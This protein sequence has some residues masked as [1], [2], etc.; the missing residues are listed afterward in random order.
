LRDPVAQWGQVVKFQQLLQKGM[1]L[2]CR[3]CWPGMHSGNDGKGKYGN[4]KLHVPISYIYQYHQ[5][6]SIAYYIHCSYDDSLSKYRFH[7]NDCIAWFAKELK[8]LAYNIK[9][10]LSTNISMADFTRND[11]IKFNTDMYCHVCEKPF[12]KDDIRVR[13]HC[14]LTERYIEAPCIQIAT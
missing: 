4:I 7:D 14:H 3:I 9:T 10:I 1:R 2:I 13:D 12:A 5:V 8:N 6:F 11:W